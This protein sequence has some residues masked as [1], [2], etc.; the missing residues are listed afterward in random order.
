MVTSIVVSQNGGCFMGLM[1][2]SGM[3]GVPNWDEHGGHSRMIGL[4]SVLGAC[5]PRECTFIKIK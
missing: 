4:S 3:V 5:V 1:R 2:V